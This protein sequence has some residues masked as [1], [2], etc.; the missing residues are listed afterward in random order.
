MIFDVSLCRHGCR[1]LPPQQKLPKGAPPGESRDGRPAAAQSFF[2]AARKFLVAQSRAPAPLRARGAVIVSR[3]PHRRSGL[4]FNAVQ[5]RVNDLGPQGQ[6]RFGCAPEQQ[7]W[8]SCTCSPS[9]CAPSIPI[10]T[11]SGF[12]CFWSLAAPCKPAG[13]PLSSD[14]SPLFDSL[15]RL[16][17][18]QT[19]R[20]KDSQAVQGQQA[21]V[22]G[23]GSAPSPGE[24]R[25]GDWRGASSGAPPG[26][27]SLPA[28]GCS[29]ICKV[30]TAFAQVRTAAGLATSPP[31]WSKRLSC[32]AA[33]RRPPTFPALPRA[34]GSRGK[35]PLFQPFSPPA[36]LLPTRSPWRH[37]PQW[38]YFLG[39]IACTVAAWALRDYGSNVLD[40][41]PVNDCLADTSPPDYG[42]MGQQVHSQAFWLRACVTESI[43]GHSAF[44]AMR[45]LR[46]MLAT[47]LPPLC[48]AAPLLPLPAGSPAHRVRDV[49]LL[50]TAPVPAAGCHKHAL[51]AA[52][53]AH[54]LLAFQAAALGRWVPGGCRLGRLG[55]A[56]MACAS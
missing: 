39:F 36:L 26:L 15:H 32:A 56:G 40:F 35:D 25:A 31:S 29:P 20:A 53:A 5:T 43:G 30:P 28:M 22:S 50:C 7:K 46:G 4:P 14:A 33:S 13:K 52:G 41:S 8:D 49:P 37:D 24:E 12:S 47:S 16:A 1:G 2:E 44:P 6:L 3:A 38:C 17:S 51:T 34:L 19:A 45:C 10:A 54:R 48:C 23:K 9:F 18:L 42:C 55:A 27:L 11:L 21:T